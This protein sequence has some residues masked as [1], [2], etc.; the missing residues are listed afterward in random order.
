MGFDI[1]FAILIA[2]LMSALCFV[3]FWFLGT[4]SCRILIEVLSYFKS[5]DN[6]VKKHTEMVKVVQYGLFCR[7]PFGVVMTKCWEGSRY[8]SFGMAVS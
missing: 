4:F 7:F 3:G 5:V 6:Y 8:L 2:I 1:I